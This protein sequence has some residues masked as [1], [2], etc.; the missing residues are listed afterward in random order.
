MSVWPTVWQEVGS[1]GGGE[2]DRLGQAIQ[3]QLPEALNTT[4]KALDGG[5]NC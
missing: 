3:A 4:L 5:I 1:L 2:P